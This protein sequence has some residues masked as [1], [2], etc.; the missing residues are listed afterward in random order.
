MRRVVD[1]LLIAKLDF[2]KKRRTASLVAGL[3][4]LLSHSFV[5]ALAAS[6]P[7]GNTR[8]DAQELAA[9][10]GIGL[11]YHA[12]EAAKLL[13]IEDQVEKL[14]E[15]KRA[16]RLD[17][18]DSEACKLQLALVKK[19]MS[20]GLEL[21]TVAAHFDR[22]ITLEQQ[23]LD[24]LTRQRDFV[25]A[26]TNDINFLQ[27]GILSII[28]DGPLEQTK[29]PHKIIAGNR[30]NIISGLTVGS[31]ALLALL[32]QRGSY[33]KSPVEPNMLG[34]TLGLDSPFG[35]QLSPVLWTYLNSPSNSANDITRRDKLLQYW[36]SA[37]VLPVNI[38]KPQ[39]VE[40]V[41]ATG[42]RHRQRC[43]SIKLITARITM[44]FDL[45]AM[46]DRLNI[47]LVELLQ[48]LD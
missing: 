14:L 16:G 47:G 36:Q 2:D 3:L 34:Q 30:L 8:I 15:Y 10:S 33:R 4:V 19:V 39:V 44:L 38:K 23:A 26:A 21:R 1:L 18:Y 46:V 5:P 28:I 32:E 40:Q 17:S 29:N 24:K 37:K 13:G 42:P 11:T 20:T 31:L 6:Q 48:A 9:Q 7:P 22:E 35:E 25:V 41:A 12:R 43:E 45:R 27:L